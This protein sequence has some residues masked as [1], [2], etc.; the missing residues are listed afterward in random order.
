MFTMSYIFYPWYSNFNQIMTILNLFW[1][2]WL[3]PER[4]DTKQ[5]CFFKFDSWCGINEVVSIFITFSILGTILYLQSVCYILLDCF[6]KRSYKTDI[7]YFASEFE[8]FPASLNHSDQRK[9]LKF[10]FTNYIDCEPQ[11]T[12]EYLVDSCY[13]NKNLR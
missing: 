7:Y 6:P 8:W 13:C 12:W 4:A 3:L 5:T 9:N 1:V 10:F 11:R 2:T